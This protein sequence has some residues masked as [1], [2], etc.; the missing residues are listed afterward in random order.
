[1]KKFLALLCAALLL[2]CAFASAEDASIV[3]FRD[4]F[5]L[6]GVLPEGYRFNR[7]SEN[8]ISL[9][10]K[11][12]SEDPAAPSFEVSVF[13]NES[14]ANVSS[15]KDMDEAALETIRQGFSEENDVQFDMI[16]T[17][18]GNRLLVTREIGSDQDFL[19]F[20][21]I[22]LGYEIE[23]TLLAAEGQSLSDAQIN[24]CMEFMRTFDV[25]PLH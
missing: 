18:T 8:D 6:S 17:A 5:Q 13:F 3:D 20:Y 11:I 21:T 12:V 14:Y 23:L 22:C 7:E 25:L 15:L 10:G 16:E 2:A 1:M 4:R 24:N 19:D 9:L